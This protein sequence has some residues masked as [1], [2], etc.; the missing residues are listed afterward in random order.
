[1]PARLGMMVPRLGEKQ[2]RETL[3]DSPLIMHF[4]FRMLVFSV[5]HFVPPPGLPQM[6]EESTDCNVR[7]C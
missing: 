5:V 2:K 7:S 3:L 4:K 6:G 1:M